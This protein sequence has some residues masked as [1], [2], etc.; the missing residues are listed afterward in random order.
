MASARWYKVGQEGLAK[1]RSLAKSHH[2]QENFSATTGQI[3]IGIDLGDQFGQCCAPGSLAVTDV[4]G[5]AAHG[6]VK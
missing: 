3:T 4:S 5:E 6:G 2:L 1:S